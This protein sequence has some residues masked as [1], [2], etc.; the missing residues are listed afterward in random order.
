MI[1]RGDAMSRKGELAERLEGSVDG[2]AASPARARAARG[3]GGIHGTN[4]D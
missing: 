3:R 4:P 2:H 1:D